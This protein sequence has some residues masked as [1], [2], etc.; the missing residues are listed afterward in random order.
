MGSLRWSHLEHPKFVATAHPGGKGQAWVKKLWIDK[1]FPEVFIENGLDKQFMYVK[2]LPGDNPHL[3]KAYWRMLSSLSPKLKKAWVESDWGVFV[4]QAFPQWDVSRHVIK[5]FEIPDTWIRMRGMDFGYENPFGCLWG[6]KDPD[7]GRIIIYRE[8]KKK[9]LTDR[10]QARFV[11]SMTGKEQIAITY[12]DP[13]SKKATKDTV[14]T[15][16]D[17]FSE[18]KVYLTKGDNNRIQGKRKI[19]R[20]LENLPDGKPGLQVF[21]SCVDFI[22]DFP[23]MILD[24]THPEDCDT[25]QEDT[26]YDCLRYLLT[27]IRNV[28][29][30]EEELAKPNPWLKIKVI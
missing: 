4:G 23:L 14:T 6:A 30:E 21:D 25:D 10:N 27:S 28:Q 3:T 26:L 24:E 8:F 16:Y 20:L 13:G 7:N 15:T 1:V 12:C 2:A 11:Y 22:E 29:L 9:K 5:P 18:E 17:V 19:E